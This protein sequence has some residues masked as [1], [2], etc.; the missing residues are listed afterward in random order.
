[1][2]HGGT[3]I[4]CWRVMQ[5]NSKPHSEF[6]EFLHKGKKTDSCCEL[7]INSSGLSTSTL[8]MDKILQMCIKGW[9]V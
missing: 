5:N 3:K 9:F 1:M 2:G 4:F 6:L 7:S 8:Q